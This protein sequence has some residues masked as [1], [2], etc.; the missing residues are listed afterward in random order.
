MMNLDKLKQDIKQGNLDISEYNPKLMSD[1][2]FGNG[3]FCFFSLG[4]LSCSSGCST[5]ECS[6]LSCS[7]GCANGCS[8]VCS[9]STICIL[10]AM[11]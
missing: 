6:A 2:F 1:M 9:N 11:L 7:N 5:Y 4:C 10:M 3:S 8:K